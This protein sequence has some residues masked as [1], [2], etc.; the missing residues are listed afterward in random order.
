MRAAFH[1]SAIAVVVGSSS[2]DKLQENQRGDVEIPQRETLTLGEM[3][4]R[5]RLRLNAVSHP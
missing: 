1:M 5:V 3:K 2:D 4:Q